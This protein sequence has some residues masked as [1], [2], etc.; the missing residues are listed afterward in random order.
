MNIVCAFMIFSIFFI[1]GPWPIS[2]LQHGRPR[3]ACSFPPP[4]VFTGRA[5]NFDPGDASNYAH[6]HGLSFSGVSAVVVGRDVRG[7]LTVLNALPVGNDAH[8]SS[9]LLSPLS[10]RSSQIGWKST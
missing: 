1:R 10:W 5:S 8:N 2:S 7:C 3:P 6:K 9:L 4:R